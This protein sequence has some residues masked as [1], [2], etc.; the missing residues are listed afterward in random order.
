MRNVFDQ[1]DGLE[2]RVT[3]ALVTA[4]AEDP[5]LLRAFLKDIARCPAPRGADLQVKEQGIPGERELGEAEAEKR[6]LPD[7]SIH[8]GERWALLIESKVTAPVRVDQLHRHLAMAARQGF[9]HARLLLITAAPHTGQV[10]SEVLAVLWKDLYAW[11][12]RHDRE[13]KWAARAAEFFEVTEARLVD[14]PGS[15]EGSMTTF[16]G[17]PFG[18]DRHYN[19]GEAKR[20]LRLAVEELRKR[21]DLAQQLSMDRDGVGRPAITGRDGESVWDFLPLR[22]ARGARLFTLYPHLTIAIGRSDVLAHITL[23]N[24]IA[25]PLRRRLQSLTRER[26]GQI[27]GEVERNMRPLVKYARG[28][29]PRFIGVQ[30]HYPSQRSQPII[31]ARLEFDLRA[32]ST[33]KT[34]GSLAVKQQPSLLDAAYASLQNRRPNYEMALGLA[35]PYRDCAMVRDRKALDLVAGAWLACKPMLEAVLTP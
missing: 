27:I 35:L 8:D 33:S 22:V 20:V 23:P 7:A 25:P 21:S 28:S 10:P 2:N 26:F 5:R 12:R 4:L 18:S 29:V 9:D 31:D 30:R 3:H 17:F 16:S 13:S 34:D 24:G 15:F 1:Y 19:Y 32:V 6:S 14:Q 11:L